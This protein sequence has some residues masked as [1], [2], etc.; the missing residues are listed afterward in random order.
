M[1]WLRPLALVAAVVLLGGIAFLGYQYMEQRRTEE[2]SL[3]FAVPPG[4]VARIQAGE[5]LELLPSTIR[6]SLHGKDTLVIR[7]D[8]TQSITV[9]PFLIAPGQRFEQR[10]YNAGTYDLI[11]TLHSS[12]RL[13]VVVEQ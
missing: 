3:I 4:S 10:Y 8:D 13:R 12:Q 9:G 7:N 11:C 1:K 5:E 2:R 6:L